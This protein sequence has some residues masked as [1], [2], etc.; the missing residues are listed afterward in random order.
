MVASRL[1]WACGNFTRWCAK[2]RRV[3][4]DVADLT[5][6]IQ[7]NGTRIDSSWAQAFAHHRVQVGVSLDGLQVDH[8]RNRV[9]HQGRGSYEMVLRGIEELKQAD[10]PWSI[11]S[12]IQPEAD[13]PLLI[14]RHFVELAPTSINYLWP[15]HTH[16]TINLARQRLRPTPVADYLI[17]LIDEWLTAGLDD[18]HIPEFWNMT[19]L[20]LGGRS[21]RENYGN[22]ASLYAFVETD[23]E[24][25]GLDVLRVCG[26]SMTRT[27]LNVMS[28]DFGWLATSNSLAADV[29]LRGLPLPTACRTCPESLTCAGGYV[30]HRYSRE[31]GFNNPSVWCADILKLFAHL[32][33]RLGVTVEETLTRRSNLLQM[34]RPMIDAASSLNR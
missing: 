27:G 8:D 26:D 7:T 30:P 13:D 5:L 19:R 29:I 4:R 18:P 28:S 3:F 34:N 2:A 16:D 11:L 20:I 9:D 22:D 33:I 6:S 1:L 14:H 24:I 10:V 17:P 21:L 32:R 31:T 12:V 23:G 25:E 15:D